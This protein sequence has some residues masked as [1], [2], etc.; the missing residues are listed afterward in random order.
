M[1]GILNRI[2]K[3]KRKPKGPG[4]PRSDFLKV[5]LVRNPQIEWSKNDE[6]NTVLRIP[7]KQEAKKRKGASKLLTKIFPEPDVKEK[8]VQLDKVGSFVWELCDSDTTIEG[9][10]N[11]LNKEYKMIPREAEITLRLYFEQLSKRGLIGF[12]IPEELRERLKGLTGDAKD[13]LASAGEQEEPQDQ[14]QKP[15]RKVKG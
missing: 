10:V 8:K 6:G 7:I 11:A 4:I 1:S 9:I 5:R 14:P 13:D 12:L 2:F 3:R 15:D